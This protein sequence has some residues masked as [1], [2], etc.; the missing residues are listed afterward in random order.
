MAWPPSAL[1]LNKYKNFEREREQEREWKK[2]RSNKHK[3]P[4]RQCAEIFSLVWQH[5]NFSY[6]SLLLRKNHKEKNTYFYKYWNRY[7]YIVKNYADWISQEKKSKGSKITIQTWKYTKYNKSW[8]FCVKQQETCLSY[9]FSILFDQLGSFCRLI[10]NK[11]N[12]VFSSNIIC[13]SL[14]YCLYFLK[15]KSNEY[16][17]FADNTHSI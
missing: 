1:Y 7:L 17:S 15:N 14:D 4:L 5:C 8:V 6:I 16:H 2:K 11:S 13:Y 12:S 9:A 3:Q 10:V